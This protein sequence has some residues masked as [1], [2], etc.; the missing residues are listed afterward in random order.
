MKRIE[1]EDARVFLGGLQLGL[2]VMPLIGCSNYLC[3]ILEEQQSRRGLSV[4]CH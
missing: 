4:P 2:H 1:T 3:K